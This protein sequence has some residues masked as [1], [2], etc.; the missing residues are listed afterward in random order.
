MSTLCDPVDCSQPGVSVQGESPGKNTGVGCHALIQ[1][2][3]PIQ[4][5]EPVSPVL[6]VDYLPLSH[7]GSPKVII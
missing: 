1:G 4:G 2:I 3:F 6:W 7:Q 5:I